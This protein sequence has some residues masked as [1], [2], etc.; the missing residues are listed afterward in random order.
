MSKNFYKN[1]KTQQINYVI[2]NPFTKEI[3]SVGTLSEKNFEKNIVQN[4]DTYDVQNKDELKFVKPTELE[5][6]PLIY[7]STTKRTP[8][9]Y[10][11]IIDNIHKKGSNSIPHITCNILYFENGCPIIQ[12]DRFSPFLTLIVHD[13]NPVYLCGQNIVIYSKATKG[14]DIDIFVKMVN[15]FIDFINETLVLEEQIDKMD[16]NENPC[17]INSITY[18]ISNFC[19]FQVKDEFINNIFQKTLANNFIKGCGGTD[20]KTKHKCQV[21]WKNSKMII[22]DEETQNVDVFYT[23]IN[24]FAFDSYKMSKEKEKNWFNN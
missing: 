5:G 17:D 16:E 9:E 19:K 22:V 1:K 20:I 7:P 21:W 8:D 15:E 4:A 10:T 24:D 18:N 12:A 11:Y 14:V 13:N 6:A 3:K 2:Y 23:P